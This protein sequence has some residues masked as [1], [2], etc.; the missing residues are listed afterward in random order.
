MA[1]NKFATMLH[2]NTNKITLILVYAV[3]EWMLIIL[4]ILNSVFSY[5]IIK[6]A[7][8]FGLKP[9]CF[10]CAR[11]GRYQDHLCE[12]HSK[13]VSELRFCSTHQ[14]LA[15]FRDMCEN[16]SSSDLGIRKERRNFVFSKVERIDVILGDVEGE[17]DLKCSCCGMNF[18]R[19]FVDESSCFV[20]HPV[21]DQV[22]KQFPDD[23]MESNYVEENQETENREEKDED[24]DEEIETEE[25]EVEVTRDS[26]SIEMDLSQFE[27]Q[28]D[29]NSQVLQFFSDNNGDQLFPF[30]LPDPQIEEHATNFE[31]EE[32]EFGDF[33]KAHENLIDFGDEEIAMEE[34]T[35]T[36]LIDTKELQDKDSDTHSVHEEDDVSI[37]PQIPALDS[38]DE[39]LHEEPS[40][41][42][43]DLHSNLQNGDLKK[44]AIKMEEIDEEKAPE[45]PSGIFSPNPF[46]KKWLFTK[47]KDSG[48]EES[49]EG[50][51]ISETD[52]C[53]PVNTTEE[54]RSALK[55]ERKA[56]RDLY[57]ELEEERNASAVAANE[58]MA[59][60]NR[61]QE[62]KA[63]MQMEALQYQRMMEEQSE[64]DQE[65]L[66]LLN[67]VMMKKDEEL[68]SYRKKVSV[69][70]AKEK[71]KA[72][73]SEDDEGASVDLYHVLE[74]ENTLD[75]ERE[76]RH[77]NAPI[78]SVL[79]LES[80]LANFED[81][82]VSILEHL[83]FL[84]TKLAALSDQEDQHF[85]NVKVTEDHYEEIHMIGFSGQ[86]IDCTIN[87]FVRNGK[88]HMGRQLF[89]L[90]EAVG[91]EDDVTVRN[92]YENGFHPSKF[93]DTAVSRFEL[94]KKR[95]DMEDEM[96]EL[97]RRLQALEADREFLK[98]C[99]GSMK[100]G[101]KGMEVLREILHHLQGLRNVNIR[102][103]SYTENVLL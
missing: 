60:I 17:V 20:I 96:D 98:R 90:F 44:L 40:T 77:P 53:D 14:K 55:A 51:V 86:D 103:K 95:I 57:L 101:D 65:A 64:Y 99:I 52:G 42:S 31:D 6:F 39:I 94:E 67:E 97:Y 102:A 89:P 78:D 62:E 85:A 8:Y 5:L 29:L 100:M 47:T 61:L 71:T 88:Q 50:S 83:R 49:F 24:E 41:S 69:Y 66:Q 10:S 75:E 26:D 15:E 12:L 63:S 35:Q 4:L 43:D 82:R 92:G 73:H 36:Q 84:E 19:K 59:M 45:T 22:E 27:N 91:A 32:H 72:T 70:E 54:L 2:N 68:E 58:T 3:L 23:L 34:E 38:C 18:E 46:H 37:G 87:G 25:L 56:L 7:Q 16:C 1:A 28:E 33:Q 80:T 13:E 74:D 11:T 81:E 48:P 9:P 76:I 93:E 30:E 79:D 21:S